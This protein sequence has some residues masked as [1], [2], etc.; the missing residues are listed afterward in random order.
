MSSEVLY[1]FTAAIA[2]STAGFVFFAIL[3]LRRL[4]DTVS[5]AL[6][7][8]AKQQ[9]HSMVLQAYRRLNY[10]CNVMYAYAS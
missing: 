4:R 5:A 7:E 2:V 6:S 1:F 3:W 10:Y 9:I 8:A